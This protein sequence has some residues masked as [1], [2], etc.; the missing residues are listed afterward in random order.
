MSPHYTEDLEYAV[1]SKKDW[2]M[3]SEVY[4]EKSKWFN[5]SINMTI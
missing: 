2:K 4:G 1:F 5:S 3:K